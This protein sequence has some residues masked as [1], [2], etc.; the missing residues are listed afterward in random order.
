MSDAGRAG[1]MI[2]LLGTKRHPQLT[3]SI[4]G[5]RMKNKTTEMRGATQTKQVL[6]LTWREAAQI[7]KKK[8][9]KK[10]KKKRCQLVTEDARL[11]SRRLLL[12]RRPPPPV[13]TLS[14][15]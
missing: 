5:M 15:R 12:L 9:A 13:A 1:V 11:W 6:L 3:T 14:R 7:A 2:L 8:A 10:M 4:P